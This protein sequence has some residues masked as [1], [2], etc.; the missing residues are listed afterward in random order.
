MA[1]PSDPRRAPPPR[2][3]WV[4]RV[5]TAVIVIV[6]LLVA[7]RWYIEPTYFATHT[8]TAGAA[9]AGGAPGAG[10]AAGGGRGGGG[11]GRFTL[12]APQPVGVAT[13]AKGDIDVILNA[14]GTVTPL[15]TVTVQSQI[16]GQLIQIGFTEG[17]MVKKGDFLAQIDP[18]PYQAALD[19]AQGQLARDQAMLKGAQVD[20]D[21]Y[22]KL[23][24][25]NS[26][27][28]QQADDQLYLVRQDQ[29]TV[30]LDQASVENA[31]LNLAYCRIVSPV[32]GKVGLRLVD[33]GNYIQAGAATS[34]T[35]ITQLQPI[36]VV[37]PVAEDYLP[38]IM[39]RSA[40]SP[41]SVT[42]LDRGQT[43][44]LA[45]GTLA[46][47]DSQID[48]TTGT[49]KL[50]AQFDNADGALFPQQFVNARLLIETKKDVVI[51]PA[52]AIQRGAQGNFVYLVRDGKTV[53][54]AN[55]TLGT[56]QAERVEVTSGLAAGDVVVVDGA[57]RLRD[58]AAI[59]IPPPAAKPA[60]PAAGTPPAPNT[61]P[62]TPGTPTNPATPS[63]PSLPN[64]PQRTP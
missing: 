44:T 4:G 32:T 54:V 21:R 38:Q 50:K 26:I 2:R 9:G 13:I 12:N 33:E 52:A 40:A 46:A 47:I 57:D 53:S 41:L 51:A 37:F 61:P 43:T 6:I 16:S 24:K 64:P 17:Q 22:Q 59:T 27:A 7:W 45:T 19:Q 60:A 48:P 20:L 11:G 25:Q 58:G 14:L 10:G 28:Q 30:Q 23:A 3:R 15:A 62:P 8:R 1:N 39:K 55:V 35:V 63:N 29:G 42:A 56:T 5:I 49:V 34:L 31:K 36:S 18:R